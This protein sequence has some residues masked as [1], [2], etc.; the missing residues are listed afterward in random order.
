MTW[1]QTYSGKFSFIDPQPEDVEIKDIV[2]SLSNICRFGGHCRE[3]YSVAQHSLLVSSFVIFDK[4]TALLHDAGEAYY[5][6][7]TS[8]F[9]WF[10]EDE[11]G[12][13]WNKIVEEIDLVVSK[14]LGTRWPLPEKVKEANLLVLATEK[15]D[16]L[17]D[18]DWEIKLPEPAFITIIPLSSKTVYFTFRRIIN[19]YFYNY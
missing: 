6:D 7:I 2:K 12:L 1:I 17:P 9:K 19:E 15:R 8:P 4:W 5:G 11:T 10:L 3:F 14:A 13:G 16:L 18:C